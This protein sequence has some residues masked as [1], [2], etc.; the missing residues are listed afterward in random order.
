[1][2]GVFF[3]MAD[4]LKGGP[5]AKAL[6]E[7]LIGRTVTLKQKDVTP[8]LALLRIGE[9]GDDIAYENAAV[10]RCEKIGI[11]VKKFLLRSDVSREEVLSAVRAINMDADIH[12]C[13]M[14]RPFPDKAVEEAASRLLLPEKDVDCMT[15]GSLASVFSGSGVGYPPCTAEAVVRLLHYY[16]IPISG[17]RVTVAGR[18]LVIGK[19]VS[20]LLLRENATVTVCHSRT[21][22][23]A[24]ECRR[25]DIVVAAIGKAKLLTKEFFAK[26]Q[27]VVD[28]GINVDA[29]GNMCGD[30][31][32][33]AAEPVVAAITP[34]PGGVGSV[35]TAVLCEHVV[36]AAEKA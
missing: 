21:E 30:C 7:E 24:G 34:V 20:M 33:E 25:A 8:C 16:D 5:C 14:F 4:I 6:T 35:T 3:A 13:L 32:F 9:R 28:V 12:G 22:D 36:R 19:P 18:S 29:A 26:G 11:S 10:K 27:V 15:S 31:D 1:M 23:L 17:R 2:Q